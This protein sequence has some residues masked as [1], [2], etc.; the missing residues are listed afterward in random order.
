MKNRKKIYEKFDGQCF[1]CLTKLSYDGFTIDHF[2]PRCFGG[3]NNKENLVPS[4]EP[5][6]RAKGHKPWFT[7]FDR[8]GILRNS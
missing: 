3:G 4:C 1:Y 8:T 5:C 6:N 2:R 7:Q